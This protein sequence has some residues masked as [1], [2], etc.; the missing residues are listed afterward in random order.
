V[1]DDNTKYARATKVI[2]E[3]GEYKPAKSGLDSLPTPI[4]DNRALNDRG[5][6]EIVGYFYVMHYY[7][8]YYKSVISGVS[9]EY[10]S[11]KTQVQKDKE[12]GIDVTLPFS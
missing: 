5:N 8:R 1:Y 2:Y 9:E 6:Y 4:V 12:A 11:D 3:N 7:K 10:G